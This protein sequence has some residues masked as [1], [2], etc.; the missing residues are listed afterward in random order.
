METIV[1]MLFIG[2][3]VVGSIAYLLYWSIILEP[4]GFIK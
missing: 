2:A 1:S 3:L 4:K